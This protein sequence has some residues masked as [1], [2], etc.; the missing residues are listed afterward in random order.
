MNAGLPGVGGASA[1]SR[2]ALAHLPEGQLYVNLLPWVQAP[3]LESGHLLLSE[4]PPLC[5][6]PNLSQ[7]VA[8]RPPPLVTSWQ[9]VLI[10][11]EGRSGACPAPSS[12]LLQAAQVCMTGSAGA[13]PRAPPVKMRKRCGLG[14]LGLAQSGQHAFRDSLCQVTG[15]AHLSLGLA[16]HKD[17]CPSGGDCGPRN[18]P[19][20]LARGGA[21]WHSSA[22]WTSWNLGGHGLL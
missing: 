16:P 5:Q 21:W 15:Y 9:N 18:N 4:G 6:L 17:F 11:L 2:L 13:Q 20:Q 14:G 3:W 22:N 10:R 19:S 7:W 8:D 1:G 12:C